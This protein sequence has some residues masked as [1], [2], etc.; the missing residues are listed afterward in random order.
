MIR[1]GVRSREAPQRSAETRGARPPDRSGPH[2][3]H[4]VSTARVVMDALDPLPELRVSASAGRRFMPRRLIVGGRG[5]LEWR[6]RRG[7]A[8]RCG[9]LRRGD[10]SDS[11][12]PR[13]A[14]IRLRPGARRL[15]VRLPRS[16]RGDGHVGTP[17]GECHRGR[18]APWGAP[19]A[20]LRERRERTAKGTARLPRPARG[21]MR[22]RTRPVRT[23]RIAR[24]HCPRGLRPASASHRCR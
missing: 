1:V 2:A 13:A 10:R 24:L 7:D 17:T 16:W 18:G 3:W 19:G 9:L 8:V 23:A 4:P 22:P 14:R 20:R 6:T 15:P 5:D 11:Q 21:A 12:E